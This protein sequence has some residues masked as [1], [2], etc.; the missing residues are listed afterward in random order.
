MNIEKNVPAP[1]RR[2]PYAEKGE[3]ER[4]L[5][6]MEVGDSIFKADRGPSWFG[7]MASQMQK[8]HGRKFVARKVEGGA[9]LWRAT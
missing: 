2:P 3:H 6:A 8:K 5:L 9:R 7:P 4:T 1:N